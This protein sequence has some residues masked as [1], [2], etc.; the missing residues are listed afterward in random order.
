MY[1]QL[2]YNKMIKLNLKQMSGA[3]NTCPTIEMHSN[4]PLRNNKK[5]AVRRIVLF[6]YAAIVVF[7]LTSCVEFLNALNTQAVTPDS[8]AGT[9]WEGSTTRR[10]IVNGAIKKNTPCTVTFTFAE[11]KVIGTTKTTED[12]RILQDFTGTYS[13]NKPDVKFNFNYEGKTSATTKATISSNTMTYT[14]ETGEKY[15]LTLKK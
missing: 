9:V 4:A 10:T 15:I 6:V 12:G 2:I 11:T 8:L 14:N 13:Y 3:N 5:N 7:N 1:N